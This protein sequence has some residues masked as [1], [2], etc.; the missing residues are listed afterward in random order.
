MKIGS[1]LK[2]VRTTTFLSI[3][4]VIIAVL[5]SLTF[6]LSSRTNLDNR[7]EEILLSWF[8]ALSLIIVIRCM[9]NVGLHYDISNQ[10]GTSGRVG[11]RGLQ[12]LRGQDS[13]CN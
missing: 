5:G 13:D 4:L 11:L 9:A 7:K 1:K 12:G 8:M 3:T 2:L 10:V 6:K